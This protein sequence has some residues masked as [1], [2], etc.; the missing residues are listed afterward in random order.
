M[1][2]DFRKFNSTA[3]IYRIENDNYKLF[4]ELADIKSKILSTHNYYQKFLINKLIT[5]YLPFF[6]G[7]EF[8]V[9]FPVDERGNSINTRIEF[10]HENINN[11]KVPFLFFHFP[12]MIN[13]CNFKHI[14]DF[15][16]SIELSPIEFKI[17]NPFNMDVQAYLYNIIYHNISCFMSEDSGKTYDSFIKTWV[18]EYKKYRDE[19]ERLTI[20]LHLINHKITNAV[21]SYVD[22]MELCRGMMFENI[23]NF[24]HIQGYT[25][26]IPVFIESRGNFYRMGLIIKKDNDIYTDYIT[27][28]NVKKDKVN[29]DIACHLIEILNLES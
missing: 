21:M 25:D 12:Q 14:N 15:I 29:A 23:L 26:M 1:K 4:V 6:N 17:G 9:K 13:E 8:V 10:T 16:C 11:G 24:N 27:M 2:D 7:E 5:E 19:I 18:M 22:K 28:K 20:S 3:A